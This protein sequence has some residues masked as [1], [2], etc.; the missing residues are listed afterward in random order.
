VAA[1]G[2]PVRA[3][4][5][6]MTELAGG[7]MEAEV[8]AS[9]QRDELGD[10]ARAVLVFREHMAR[11]N[12]QAAEQEAERARAE[13]EKRQALIAM[14]GTIEAATGSAL[15]QIGDRTTAM[16]ATADAMSTSA[17]RTGNSAQDAAASAAQALGIAQ[18]VASAAEQLAASIRGIGGEV[19]RSTALVGRAVAAGTET[20][21]A[22]VALNQEVERIGVVADMISE[23]A[24][25]TNL[26]ALNATIEAA[27]AGE[28]G[29]GFAVV[30]GE[31]KALAMQTAR[32]T[33]EITRHI[34]QVR[35]A[36]G[37]SV[38]AVARIEQTIAE[39]SAIAGSIASAV[40]QQD[41]ATA[42]IARNVAE[43]AVAANAMTGR[44]GELSSLAADT[45][46]HAGDLR[47]NI[48]ALDRAVEDLRHSV[49]QVVRTSTA[50]VDRRQARRHQV[51]LAARLAI[52]GQR[53][54]D[55]RVG[56]LS[57]GGASLCGVSGLAAGTRG[58]LRLDG[59][60]VALPCIV[61]ASDE[62]RVHLAFDPDAA[63]TLQ[64]I[65]DRLITQKAA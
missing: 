13:A 62:D 10:M 59:V 57:A 3:L 5:R 15:Q 49:I 56:D 31:V 17:A 6:T 23:I 2:R 14:A 30:A 38:T 42:E 16:A 55:V 21:S 18:T 43:A 37:A 36:T 46:R 1:I 4:T 40:A 58:V 39:I 61:R 26:L 41:G 25:R 33:A 54:L 60:A 52:A 11:G 28:A 9:D 24:A 22:I 29:K 12:R 51:D 65:I 35:T 7:N 63:A 8:G 45:D 64:P 32:S 20:R 34:G 27:R 48:V 53:E 50:E 44:T 19:G 47:D